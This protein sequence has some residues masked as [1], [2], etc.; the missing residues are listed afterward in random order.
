MEI[1]VDTQ[2]PVLSAE[3]A[4]RQAQDVAAA[5]AAAAAAAAAAAQQATQ[6]VAAAAAQ[7][8]AA[9]AQQATAA[10]AATAQQTDEVMDGLKRIVVADADEI[11][12]EVKR[13]RRKEMLNARR[14]EMGLPDVAG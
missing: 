5:T 3:L 6:R 13:A 8:A 4:R 10:A 7:Q 1:D 11:P 2:D 12:A 9:A 14:H